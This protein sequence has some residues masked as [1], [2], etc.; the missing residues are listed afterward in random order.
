[1]SQ[2]PFFTR[3]R[4]GILGVLLL[5]ILVYVP[6]MTGL[7][8]WDDKG[9][10][11]GSAIGGGK[12]W[13]QCFEEPFNYHYYRPLVSAS[14]FLDRTLFGTAP[15]LYH[16]TNVLIHAAATA[17]LIWLVVAAFGNRRLALLSGLFFAV[18]PGQVGAVAWI[19]GRTDSLCAL[20]VVAMALGLVKWHQGRHLGWMALSAASLL[21]AMMTKEQAAVLL[22]LAPAA[23]WAFGKQP[24]RLRLAAWSSVPFGVMAAV[25][26]GL[27]L[28]HYPDPFKAT[29]PTVLELIA[30][31]G[32]T[33]SHYV[34]LFFAPN[35][36]SMHSFS[37]ENYASPLWTALG[38]GLFA[39]LIFGF[40]RLWKQSR[41][42]AWFALLA[43]LIFLPVS[44]AVPMPSLLVGPYRISVG[45]PAIAVL[46]AAGCLWLWA[47]K[48][49]SLALVP[50]L[51]ALAGVA[52]TPWGAAQFQSE[53]Q[54][55]GTVAKYD[56]D[57]IIL[58][59]NYVVTLAV[60]G[61][62]KEALE[63]SEALLQ[64]VFAGDEWLDYKNVPALLDANPKVRK[65]VEQNQG[66]R[67]ATEEILANVFIRHG[68]ILSNLD[69]VE[70]ATQALRCGV[71]L[72]NTN[73]AGWFNLGKQL[74]GEE[75]AQCFRRALA[76]NT[77]HSGAAYALGSHFLQKN[78]LRQAEKL[79]VQ[80]TRG[81]EPFGDAFLDLAQVQYKLGQVTAARQNLAKAERT[82]VDPEKL[83]AVRESLGG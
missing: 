38:L 40:V 47:S 51:G 55:F 53:K 31:L 58:R 23:A 17:L 4:L 48:W 20:F 73:E 82:I 57:S 61:E 14:F 21:A 65:W 39:G 6:C 64:T 34:L 1:V 30:R 69:R 50:A 78:D 11:H 75:A 74:Q 9:I 46:S 67:A 76:C 49:R 10:L 71:T 72:D 37:L 18:Q 28:A 7:P 5:S 54:F 32:K 29:S 62:S 24:D 3:W 2:E 66:T 41:E 33:T 16:Q 22:L 77:K 26:V 56:P 68:L 36:W 25:F 15:M 8:V 83:R 12:T 44:N 42:L 43:L 52:L 13:A 60:L 27:W 63:H 45:G 19:G 59:S 81:S 70:E 79:F 80:A 35:P